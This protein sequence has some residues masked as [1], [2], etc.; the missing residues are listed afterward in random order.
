MIHLENYRKRAMVLRGAIRMVAD[1]PWFQET[2]GIMPQTIPMIVFRDPRYAVIY[3]LYRNLKH[4]KDSLSISSFYQFQWK[5]T[6][7]LYELWCFLQFIKA[8]YAKD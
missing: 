3:R 6:D 8:L 5:R 7:K 1:A 4:P 2:K